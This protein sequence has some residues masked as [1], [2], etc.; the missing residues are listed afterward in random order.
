VLPEFARGSRWLFAAVAAA[1]VA[2]MLDVQAEE[3]SPLEMAL[4]PLL[5]GEKPGQEEEAYVKYRYEHTKLFTSDP[6]PVQLGGV[7]VKLTSFFITAQRRFDNERHSQ[8]RPY[9][10]DYLNF[11]ST[12]AGILPG[13]D[14]NVT[15]G[16]AIL[17]DNLELTP[18]GD[19][20]TD[21]FLG[22]TWMFYSNN[23]VDFFMGLLARVFLPTGG[24]ANPVQLGPSEISE[25]VE[26]RLTTAKDFPYNWTANYDIGWVYF[27]GTTPDDVDDVFL[28]NLAI[29]YQATDWLQPVV[30]INYLHLF[31]VGE[32]DSDDLALSAGFLMPLK[33][34]RIELGVQQVVAGRNRDQ[35]TAISLTFAYTF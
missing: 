26:I 4:M 23:D 8:D 21:V 24:Q 13:L 9:R 31:R 12:T 25:A 29:G 27:F 17:R 32:P 22:S 30:E 34:T 1:V 7:Q 33:R 19:G 20:L 11:I 15:M 2:C 5:W 6:F 35:F 18:T 10:S 3:F 28:T 14:F 16:Y